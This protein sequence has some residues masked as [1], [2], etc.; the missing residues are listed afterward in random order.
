[1]LNKEEIINNF[2]LTNKSLLVI[3]LNEYNSRYLIAHRL[4][5]IYDIK[6]KKGLYDKEIYKIMFYYKNYF[7]YYYIS[8]FAEFQKSLQKIGKNV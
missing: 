3:R 4:I 2:Y 8:S 7:C 1:M 5:Y 6:I